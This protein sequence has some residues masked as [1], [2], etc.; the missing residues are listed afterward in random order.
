MTNFDLVFYNLLVK[1][2]P[3]KH[4]SNTYKYLDKRFKSQDSYSTSC[5]DCIFP[6]FFNTQFYNNIYYI[7]TPRLLHR[8]FLTL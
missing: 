2:A 7:T 3:V 1:F 5:D 8:H 4:N 6:K